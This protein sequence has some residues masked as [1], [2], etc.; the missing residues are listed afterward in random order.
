MQKTNREKAFTLIELLV[1]IS[2][3]ALLLSILMP[4]LQRAKKAAQFVVCQSNQKQWGVAFNLYLADYEGKLPMCWEGYND[5]L[6]TSKP[7]KD[8]KLWLQKLTPYVA[9]KEVDDLNEVMAGEF[10]EENSVFFCPTWKKEAWHG[11]LGYG[12]N[13]WLKRPENNDRTGGEYVNVNR[14][15]RPSDKILLGD[16]TNY[17]L[18]THDQKFWVHI[19]DVDRASAIPYEPENNPDSYSYSVKYGFYGAAPERHS[20][21]AAYLMVD[22]SL[23]IF[24]KEEAYKQLCFEEPYFG[25]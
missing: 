8:L 21:R 5:D 23:K 2:I 12:M 13:L 9:H 10:L 25:K 16:S 18:Y 6:Y 22:S 3:I 1:V 14:L 7:W 15:M 20:G 19:S 24:N 11:K 17:H 4:S